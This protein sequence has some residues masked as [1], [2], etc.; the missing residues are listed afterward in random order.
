MKCVC[1]QYLEALANLVEKSTSETGGGGGEGGGGG[2]GV[3]GGKEA[4]PFL[5]SIHLTFVPDEEIGGADG[6]GELLETKEF[7]SL[8]PIALAL[9]EGLAN[10]RSAFTVFYGERT[11]WY[12][13]IDSLDSDVTRRPRPHTHTRK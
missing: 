9:D 10:P 8:M 13:V 6:M 11:P 12:L 7:Q 5:R 2:G 4:T 3:G 1:V